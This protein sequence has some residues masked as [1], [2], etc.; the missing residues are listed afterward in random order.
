MSRLLLVLFSFLVFSGCVT[1]GENFSSD[2]SWLDQNKPSKQQVKKIM[3]DPYKVGS[4]NGTPT[5]T[6]GYYKHRL[7]GESEIKELKIYWD[8]DQL[9]T[10]SFSSSFPEDIKKHS[11]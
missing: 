2:T 4:S 1:R 7:F 3:G 9:K 8:E 6:Y 5:W 10:F 11:Y